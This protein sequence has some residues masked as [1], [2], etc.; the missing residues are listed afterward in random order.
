MD[1]L[2]KIKSGSQVTKEIPWPGDDA[3]IKM[4]ILNDN[5]YLQATLAADK[6]LPKVSVANVNRYN[7]ELETQLLHKSITDPETGRNLGN[8]SEFRQLL[9]P[10]I[11]SVLID[12]LDALHTEHSPDPNTLSEEEFDKLF[13]EI[14]KN[15]TKTVGS[16]SNIHTL[17]KLVT[18]LASKQKK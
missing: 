4:R 14:K 13:L 7:A 3:I 12:E 5:D 16:V 9:T 10:E 1:L 15:A 17:R 11:K 2:Q 6:L 8:I 18:I